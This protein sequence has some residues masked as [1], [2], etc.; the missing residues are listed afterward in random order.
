MSVHRSPM[1]VAKSPLPSEIRRFHTAGR[2]KSSRLILSRQ[3]CLNHFM[4][5]TFLLIGCS[6]YLLPLG[7]QK[8]D[9]QIQSYRVSKDSSG[10][11][12]P[13]GGAP[14]MGSNAGATPSGNPAP[15]MGNAGVPPAGTDMQSMGASMG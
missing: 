7:C 2:G 9:D 1:P 5:R 3:T 12:M 14:M 10:P 4:R 11:S 8:N 6:L 13:M 15:M